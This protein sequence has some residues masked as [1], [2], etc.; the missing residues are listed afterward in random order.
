MPFHNTSQCISKALKIE[1]IARAH[2]DQHDLTSGSQLP[3]KFHLQPL[4][5]F[6]LGLLEVPDI[7]KK[8]FSASGTPLMLFPLSWV[9]IPLLFAW[10]THLILK[11]HIFRDASRTV[12]NKLLSFSLL[13]FSI[14]VH[15]ILFME[16]TIIYYYTCT[17]AYIFVYLPH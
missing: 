13:L 11:Y 17:C 1:F 3:I 12:L 16:L 14:Y 6:A 7:Q 15:F 8:L 4:S 5:L 2:R 10:L 9:H